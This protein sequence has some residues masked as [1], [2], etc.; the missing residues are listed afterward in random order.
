MDETDLCTQRHNITRRHALERD[1]RRT[2]K[3]PRNH[4]E[5]ASFESGSLNDS[6]TLTLSHL[7]DLPPAQIHRLSEKDRT[8]RDSPR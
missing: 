7:N 6:T 2:V 1:H 5:I 8:L 3:L 4:S